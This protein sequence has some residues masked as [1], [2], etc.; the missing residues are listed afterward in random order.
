[1]RGLSFVL[2][3]VPI[4]MGAIMPHA[5]AQMR[6]DNAGLTKSSHGDNGGKAAQQ[7]VTINLALKDGKFYLGEIPSQLTE[8]SVQAID[9]ETLLK[10]GAPILK[11]AMIVTVRKLPVASG[12]V[13]LKDLKDIAALP[14][15]FDI[16]QNT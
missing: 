12:F 15:D 4:V 5:L 8:E 1:M 10:L 11:E 2:V 7:V 6:D 9:Q 13:K 14:F 3:L 16:G